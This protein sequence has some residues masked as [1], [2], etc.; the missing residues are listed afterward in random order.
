MEGQPQVEFRVL[1]PVEVSRDGEPVRLGGPRQRALLSLLLLERGRPT[2]ADRLVDELWSAEP[3]DG[4]D[5]TL[6]SY[7]SRLRAALDGVA[8]L[9]GTSA[10]YALEVGDARVDAH[11]F[12]AAVRVAEDDLRRRRLRRAATSLRAALE[13]W[14]GAAFGE[15][16]VDGALR[17]E[18]DRLEELRLHALELRIEADLGLGGGAELIDELE[19]LAAA[20]PYRESIWRQLMLALYRSERQADALHAF[21]RARKALDEHLGIEPGIAL[22]ELQAAILRQ[23]V[24]S[25]EAA[26]ESHNLP[27][28]ITSFVGRER[29]IAEAREVV[30]A[31]RLVTLVGVGGV[32]KTRLGLEVARTVGDD[33]HDGAWFVDFA[34][35]VDPDLLATHIGGAIGVRE[36]PG[37]EPIGR[38]VAHLR[39]LEVL[40]VF[41]NCEHLREPIA[42]LATRLLAAS[43]GLHILATSREVLGV[44]GE[45]DYDVP[46]LSL[47]RPDASLESM[48]SSEAVRL[49]IDRARAARPGLADDDATLAAI[50]RIC[51]DL[52]GLPLALELAAARARV[53]SATEIGERLHDRFR[54][55]VSWRRLTT[56]RHRTLLEAMDWSHELLD[57]E[58]QR[59]LAELSVFSGGFTLEA[60]QGVATGAAADRALDL[61]ERLTDASLVIVDH[62]V[63]PT[64]YRVLETVRQYGAARLESDGRTEALRERHAGYFGAF[65]EAAVNRLRGSAV[66]SEWVVRLDRD[67]EN[68][69]AAF[70]WSLARGDH[71]R[72]L[73][74]A[75]ALWRYWWIRGEPTQGR[76]W[77]QR[78][79][80][81][82]PASA[83]LLR[84][85]GFVGV[86][87]LSWALG[88]FDEAEQAA[89]QA[90]ELFVEL[91]ES[92]EVANAANT[93]GLI[94]IARG[95]NP[96]ART[97][98]EESI[99]RISASDAEATNKRRRLGVGYDNLGS[100][101][102][103]LGE[104]DEARR[105]YDA[106]RALNVEI[107][108]VEGVAMNDLHLAILDAEAGALDDARRRLASAID[109][110]R[111][112][113]FLHYAAE[114]LEAASVIA[115]GLGLPTE[116][117]F[118]L[119]AAGHI[120]EQL[121]S[122]PVPFMARLREREAAAA[123]AALP[124]GTYERAE[125][126]GLAAPT[127]DAIG[128]VLELL[129]GGPDRPPQGAADR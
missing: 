43:P 127:G 46:P 59:L 108:D 109:V 23:D 12:E 106:A 15:L 55:L 62:D 80:E 29:E 33:L 93:L 3:P 78:S 11:R 60:I 122:P 48:R 89:G 19:S 96:S 120:R 124:D 42:Q 118:A 82:A 101:A 70:E 8:T 65:A 44:A 72:A 40:L 81:G 91:D 53:L 126:E 90:K 22:T 58:A 74:I 20:H 18:A 35:V 10:G 25:P 84:A 50:G 86:G 83:P 28:P 16:A 123:R 6:R 63:E 51:A 69:R 38:L 76:A 94:A 14:R 5:V 88:D 45:S 112:V 85:R 121:G 21:H 26:A 2:S 17:V 37:I 68:V 30:L 52:D 9:E 66:Q 61:V 105:H 73:R 1:G 41:D 39:E 129:G 104:D 111:R 103:E 27:S 115:N 95:D 77:L 36:Q 47:P 119:G 4:A 56:A 71:D 75:E 87:G 97:L 114:C 98:F 92:L 24:P 128:R 34:P 13:S 102:H 107:A 113:D 7:I 49:F 79:L 64:R 116:A 117:A 31:H 54:F 100:T 67:R 57:P 125:A 32:G 110:Y 99:R